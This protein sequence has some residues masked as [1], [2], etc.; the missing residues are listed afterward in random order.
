MG[1][2]EYK[3]QVIIDAQPD[4]VW[5]VLTD[6]ETYGQWNDFYRKVVSRGND[7]DSIRMHVTL[8]A[9][10]VVSIEK[11][12][13]CEKNKHLRWGLNNFLLRSG[14]S[15]TLTP[16][17]GGK[18]QVTSVFKAAGLVAIIAMPL[19]GKQIQAGMEN[20]LDCMKQRVEIG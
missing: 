16:I 8:G 4:Q 11:I 7:G 5:E 1:M 9:I 12:Q 14:V 6:F 2:V 18:T 15:R 19:F 10:K 17:E 3:Y 20:F 13:H